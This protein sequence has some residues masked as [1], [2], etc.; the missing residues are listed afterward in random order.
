[1]DTVRDKL[2]GRLHVALAL[3]VAWLIATSPWIAMYRRVPAG[4]GLLN[5]SHVV[6]GCAA[7][8]LATLYLFAC[9]R[10][11]RWRVY[12]PWLAGQGGATLRDLAGLARG[13][14]PSAE[15]GGLFA[16]IEGLTLVALLATAATGAAWWAAHGSADALAWRGGHAIAADALIGLAVAHVATVSLHL[17]EMLRD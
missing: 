10:A 17:L 12:F 9:T 4:P 14:I 13:T 5:G 8:V 15:G 11:G 2:T 7:L 6:L 16:T 3:I 1:M